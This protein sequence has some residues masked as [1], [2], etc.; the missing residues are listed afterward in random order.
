MQVYY[1]ESMKGISRGNTL[2]LSQVDA[3][4]YRDF[5]TNQVLAKD[6]M[7]VRVTYDGVYRGLSQIMD[8]RLNLLQKYTEEDPETGKNNIDVEFEEM[9]LAYNSH[10]HLLDPDYDANIDQNEEHVYMYLGDDQGYIKLWE[11]SYF[12]KKAGLQPV[13]GYIE[14]RGDQFFPNRK[15]FVNVATY[16]GRLRKTAQM[17]SFRNSK[18][19]DPEDSGTLIRQVLAHRLSIISLDKHSSGGLISCSKDC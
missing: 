4:T 17:S 3:S 13:P 9:R 12:L 7:R 15:E 8:V 1:G 18:P 11:L 16:S 5:K 2:K 6:E 14:Q 10:M 19:Y